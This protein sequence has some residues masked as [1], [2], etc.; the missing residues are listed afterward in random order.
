MALNS[1][2]Y[3]WFIVSSTTAARCYHT[4][5]ALTMSHHTRV[6]ATA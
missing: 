2:A 3:E 5:A 1:H 6:G 4:L